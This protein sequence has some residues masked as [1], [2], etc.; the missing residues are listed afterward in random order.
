VSLPCR[1][2]SL[3]LTVWIQLMPI[4]SVHPCM[5][6]TEATR[7]GIWYGATGVSLA[8]NVSWA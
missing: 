6:N 2:F 3:S 1:S 8:E 5:W 7:L 4:A